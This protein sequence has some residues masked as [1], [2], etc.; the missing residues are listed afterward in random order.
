MK[1]ILQSMRG[2]RRD[3]ILAPLLKMLEA[4]LDLFVPFIMK[5][6]INVGIA[7]GDR[8]YVLTHAALLVGI[9]VF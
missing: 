8:H 5:D 2:Y 9:G 7:Q 4:L 6:L 3:S 1:I